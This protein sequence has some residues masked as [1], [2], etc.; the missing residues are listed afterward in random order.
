VKIVADEVFKKANFLLRILKDLTPR[1]I[2]DNESLRAY[3]KEFHAIWRQSI[4]KDNE[5]LR[6]INVEQI[7]FYRTL[8]TVRRSLELIGAVKE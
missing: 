2:A 3:A 7:I 5:A 4:N 8:L 6:K 1:E